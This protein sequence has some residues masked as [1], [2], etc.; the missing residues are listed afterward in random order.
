MQKK[1]QN[2]L[3]AIET[4]RLK[5]V[6]EALAIKNGTESKTPQFPSLE[7]AMKKDGVFDYMIGQDQHP[8]LNHGY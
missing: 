7:E 4:L 2:Q 3:D 6:A 8:F 1:R 5:E